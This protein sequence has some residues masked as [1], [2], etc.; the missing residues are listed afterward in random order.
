MIEIVE[1]ITSGASVAV[2]ATIELPFELRQ[3]SRLSTILASGEAVLVKLPRGEVLRDGDLL[4]AGDGRVVAVV[5]KRERL[6]HCQSNNAT[7][8]ARWAY[9]L[10]NRHLPV[11]LGDG[12]LRIANDP[13]ID[14]ML[15]GLGAEPVDVMAAFEPESGAYR[16]VHAHAG[17]DGQSGPRI[18]DHAATEQSHK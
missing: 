6:I 5:A 13:V 8:L 14:A 4:R 18:H 7:E 9:H 3:K 16:G 17:S 2:C 11:Q 15:R 1:K 10:G 12:Y